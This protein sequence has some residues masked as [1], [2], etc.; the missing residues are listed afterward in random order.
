V[1]SGGGAG[2]YASLALDSGGIPVISYRENSSLRLARCNNNSNCDA[3]TF[4][5]LTGLG[6][7]FTSIALDS[8]GIPVISF[9]DAVND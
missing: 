5:T 6:A 1:E 8:G 9:R 7:G 2:V 3:P 4:V